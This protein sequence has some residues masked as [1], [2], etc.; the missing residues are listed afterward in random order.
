MRKATRRHI[1]EGSSLY[2]HGRGNLKWH[3]RF[4]VL[5]FVDRKCRNRRGPRDWV[6]SISA[7]DIFILKYRVIILSDNY[8]LSLPVGAFVVLKKFTHP[9]VHRHCGTAVANDKRKVLYTTT[10]LSEGRSILSQSESKDM[11]NCVSEVHLLKD[12]THSLKVWILSD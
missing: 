2:S 9:T 8:Q 7:R 3:I 5:T 12:V 11:Q 4:T 10:A 1:P 6:L